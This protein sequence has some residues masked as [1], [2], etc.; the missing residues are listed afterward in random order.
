MGY[1]HI[2]EVQ[3]GVQKVQEFRIEM[4]PQLSFA[5]RHVLG[6]GVMGVRDHYNFISLW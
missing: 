6:V 2:Q 5:V 3:S 4:L 1:R